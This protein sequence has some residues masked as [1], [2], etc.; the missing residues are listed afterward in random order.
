MSL[1]GPGAA[2]PMTLHHGLLSGVTQ[3]L[4]TEKSTLRAQVGRCAKHQMRDRCEAE[5][6]I[7]RGTEHLPRGGEDDRRHGVRGKGDAPERS[8]IK[9]S[10]R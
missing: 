10:P 4:S 6:E 7:E 5:R 2:I 8:P 1:M 3:T 9:I